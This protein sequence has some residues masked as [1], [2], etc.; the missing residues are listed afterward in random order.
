MKRLDKVFEWLQSHSI[1]KAVRSLVSLTL[2]K[3]PDP[4]K[5]VIKEAML[6]HTQP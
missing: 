3:S 6:R 5:D 4:V 1:G 2:D